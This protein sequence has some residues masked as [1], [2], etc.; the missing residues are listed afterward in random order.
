M[1]GPPCS[2]CMGAKM[3]KMYPHAYCHKRVHRC[4][5]CCMHH[6]SGSAR[7]VNPVQCPPEFS[8]KHPILKCTLEMPILM[9]CGIMNRKRWTI[10]WMKTPPKLDGRFVHTLF[11]KGMG[12]VYLRVGKV[13]FVPTTS[14]HGNLH[15][16]GDTC[17]YIRGQS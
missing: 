6:V 9:R 3:G 5:G 16:N 4:M 11:R 10:K 13:G 15:A 8:H 14:G 17:G 7:S 1:L 12:S 2:L